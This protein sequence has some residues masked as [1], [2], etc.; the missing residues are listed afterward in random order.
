METK[1]LPNQIRHWTGYTSAVKEH[2]VQPGAYLSPR[3]AEYLSGSLCLFGFFC[4]YFAVRVSDVSALNESF[5]PCVSH[6][7]GLPPGWTEPRPGTVS[8]DIVESMF[9]V[10]NQADRF[11]LLLLTSLFPLLE[12]KQEAEVRLPFYRNRGAGVR[13]AVVMPACFFKNM[14]GCVFESSCGAIESF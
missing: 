3:V 12:G 7:P 10:G 11:A 13:T 14:S 2:G 9:P 1:D 4:F 8:K 6:L 5:E